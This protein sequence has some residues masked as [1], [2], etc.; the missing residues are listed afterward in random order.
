M[1]SINVV[2]LVSSSCSSTFLLHR[3]ARLIS[4]SLQVMVCAC[5]FE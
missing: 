4:V 3:M 5:M 1:L 2:Y